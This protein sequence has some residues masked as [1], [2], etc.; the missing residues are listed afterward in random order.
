MSARHVRGGF[1]A[2]KT[3]LS[4]GGYRSK[5]P[6]WGPLINLNLEAMRSARYQRYSAHIS[7]VSAVVTEPHIWQAFN[8]DHASVARLQRANACGCPGHNQVSGV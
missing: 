7:P 6:P 4:P 2:L 8:R 3:N 5:E 1:Q